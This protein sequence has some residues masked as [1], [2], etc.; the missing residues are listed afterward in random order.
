[1]GAVISE[2]D[3]L[4]LKYEIKVLLQEKQVYQDLNQLDVLI[5]KRQGLLETL[6]DSLRLYF[7]ILGVVSAIIDIQVSQYANEGSVGA[8]HNTGLLQDAKKENIESA[9]NYKLT[10]DLHHEYEEELDEGTKIE[11]ESRLRKTIEEKHHMIRTGIRETFGVQF[12][13]M[14]FQN[15]SIV[16][17][18]STDQPEAMAESQFMQR[19]E[20]IQQW[21]KRLVQHVF[22]FE[23][24]NNSHE[25]FL[26]LRITMD[27]FFS[28]TTTLLLPPT[29]GTKNVN[30]ATEKSRGHKR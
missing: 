15:G 13:G 6:H 24:G 17:I 3:L 2:S 29:S 5:K 25:Q 18:I 16:V 21:A 9:Q 11:L 14:E 1:M 20:D 22:P 30:K 27:R 19:K 10:I 23:F 12:E 26:K 7:Q 8:M 28:S 4:D